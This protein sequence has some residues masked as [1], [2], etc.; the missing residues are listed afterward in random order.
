MLVTNA[1]SYYKGTA[2]KKILD[3]VL[4]KELFINDGDSWKRQRR[5]MQPA[6]HSK[7]IETYAQTMVNY[8][9]DL[10]NVWQ[11]NQLG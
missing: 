3:P 1:D 9:L 6:F 8:A 7:R 2:S 5:L 4:G 11:D 10:A